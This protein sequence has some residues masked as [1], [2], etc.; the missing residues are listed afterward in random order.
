MAALTRAEVKNYILLKDTVVEQ[1][2]VDLPATTAGRRLTNQNVTEILRVTTATESSAAQY[3]TADYKL[4]DDIN[5]YT[6]VS[7]ISTGGLS[8]GGAA[9]FSYSYNEYD[10]DIDNLIPQVEEDV[11]EYLNNYFED[12]IIYVNKVSGL[13]FVGGGPDTITDDNADFSTA[14]FESG[15]DVA[16]RGGSNYGIHTLAGVTAGTLTL[17]SSNALV[18]QDQDV[19]FNHVG[20]IKISRINWPANL[21]PYIAKMVWYRMNKSRPD[22]VKSE[23]LDDYSIT[24][25]NGNAYPAEVLEG[26][27]KFRKAVL[28]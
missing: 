6:L 22:N 2:T 1:E 21:K 28:V 24:Y 5:N 19:S 26:L 8:T 15:M 12:N 16:V 13:A 9:L 4:T 18:D 11:C 27:R 23:R 20:G 3:T 7:N 17:D 25:I 14:G 10:G